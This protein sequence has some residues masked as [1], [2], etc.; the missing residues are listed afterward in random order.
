MYYAIVNG[1]IMQNKSIN[2]K[3]PYNLPKKI[4]VSPQL[5]EHGNISEITRDKPEPD[6]DGQGGCSNYP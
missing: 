5:S 3:I 2:K 4:Y 1:G 6:D